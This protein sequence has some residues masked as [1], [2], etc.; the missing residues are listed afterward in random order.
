MATSKKYWGEGDYYN[1]CLHLDPRV[2]KTLRKMAIDDECTAGSLASEAIVFYIKY[3]R[4]IA[5]QE[6]KVADKLLAEQEYEE[7]LETMLSL[8]HKKR[9]LKAAKSKKK[10]DAKALLSRRAW[11]RRYPNRAWPGKFVADAQKTEKS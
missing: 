1:V 5:L 11:H 10:N 3:L 8:W 9:S 4:K 7:A 6:E 2:W